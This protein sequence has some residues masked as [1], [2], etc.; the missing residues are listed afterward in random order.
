MT[1]PKIKQLSYY[2]KDL[3]E[4]LYEWDYDEITMR[5]EWSNL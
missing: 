3:E 4:G 5:T 1:K 2:L